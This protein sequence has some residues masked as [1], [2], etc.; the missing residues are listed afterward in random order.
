MVK[1]QPVIPTW[2]V[3]L[4]SNYPAGLTRKCLAKSVKR[5]FVNELE[6]VREQSIICSR[7]NKKKFANNLQKVRELFLASLLCGARDR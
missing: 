3:M 4:V 2:L 1:S 7:R 5:Q 6:L